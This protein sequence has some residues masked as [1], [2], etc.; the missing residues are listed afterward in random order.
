MIVL[1]VM[2]QVFYCTNTRV[3]SMFVQIMVSVL[4]RRGFSCCF[5]NFLEVKRASNKYT[6]SNITIIE[7]ISGATS[8]F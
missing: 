6:Y 2:I 1:L 4:K 3:A 5:L 7:S 8:Q